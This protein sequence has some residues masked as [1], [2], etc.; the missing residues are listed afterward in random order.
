[1]RTARAPTRPRTA[2]CVQ[3]TRARAGA[4]HTPRAI[5][6]RPASMQPPRHTL[7]A[8]PTLA[9]APLARDPSRGAALRDM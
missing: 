8:P 3:P 6:P 4:A 5:P 9:F 7:A 2:R 1:M